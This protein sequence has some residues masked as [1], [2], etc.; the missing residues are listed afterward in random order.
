MRTEKLTLSEYLRL[1][2]KVEK[3]DWSKAYSDYGDKNKEIPIVSFKDKGETNNYGEKLWDFTFKNGNTHRY[4]ISWIILN[5]NFVLDE[6][7]LS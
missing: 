6:F 3:I 4:A 2:G 5:V 1:G 7:Y